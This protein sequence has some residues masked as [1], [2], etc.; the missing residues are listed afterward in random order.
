MH[1]YEELGIYS[2]IPA[3]YAY[4][5]YDEVREDLVHT[6]RSVLSA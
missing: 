5:A 3:L 4:P 6:E 2:Q 1:G